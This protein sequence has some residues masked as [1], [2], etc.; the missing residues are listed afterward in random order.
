ME[1][2]PLTP[3][4]KSLF[5]ISLL[6]IISTI[7]FYSCDFIDNKLTVANSSKDSIAFIIENE[8]NYFQT[9][10]TDTLRNTEKLKYQDKVI[11]L[12]V[13]Q[14]AQRGIYFI[15]H[16][17]HKKIRTFNVKWESLIKHHPSKK[18]VVYFFPVNV[19]TSGKYNWKDIWSNSVYLKRLEYT[20]DQLED[21]NWT[22]EYK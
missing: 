13:N 8:T 12:N 1:K 20:I 21:N 17:E 14:E 5:F 18:L 2:I 10:S 4:W 7:S 15:A 11:Q 9:I 22:V 6:I 16:D 19:F 3:Y